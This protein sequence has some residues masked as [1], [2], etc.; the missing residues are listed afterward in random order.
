[1]RGTDRWIAPVLVLLFVALTAPLSAQTGSRL[2]RMQDEAR[3]YLQSIEKQMQMLKD[4]VASSQPDDAT[5]LEK[6]RD[7]LI[8]SLLNDEMKRISEQLSDEKYDVAL[9]DRVIE[10]RKNLEFI[11]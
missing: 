1:M 6:A 10:V 8:E 11:L 4:K 2:S 9:L 5:R 7:R 3:E